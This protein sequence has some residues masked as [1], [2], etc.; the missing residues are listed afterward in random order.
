MK[1][2]RRD[3][4]TQTRLQINQVLAFFIFSSSPQERI[5]WIPLSM[6]ANTAATHTNCI[7]LAIKPFVNLSNA[8]LV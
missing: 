6:S 5:S 2:A 3:M 4:T 1:N 7:K 8:S